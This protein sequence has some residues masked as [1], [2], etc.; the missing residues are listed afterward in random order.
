MASSSR[1]SAKGRGG[2]FPGKGGSS[3]SGKAVVSRGSGDNDDSSSSGLGSPEPLGDILGRPTVDP[4]YRSG[5]RFP[6]VPA[7][8]QPPLA[9]WEWLVM[10]KDAAADV[11]WTPNFRE[12][13]DLQIQ[14]NEMLA[15]PLVFDF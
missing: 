15:V 8:L 9:D 2:T 5:E 10:R 7:S 14:R 4:W 3:V 13:R 11:A 6:S 12:I 1:R